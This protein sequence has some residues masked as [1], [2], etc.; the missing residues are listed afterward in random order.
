[1]RGIIFYTNFAESY[2]SLLKRGIVGTFHHVSDKHLDRYLAEFDWKWNT[3]DQ[4]D[5][6]RTCDTIRSAPNKRLTYRKGAN[7]LI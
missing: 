2:H 3:R 1:V 5:G 6:E 7:A 4:T